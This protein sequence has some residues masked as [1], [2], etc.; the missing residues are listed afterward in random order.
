MTVITGTLNEDNFAKSPSTFDGIELIVNGSDMSVMG[1]SSNSSI[2]G[3][4]FHLNYDG[5]PE[6]LESL[7]LVVKK[8]VGYQKVNQKIEV[9]SLKDDPVI[10]AGKQLWIKNIAKTEQGIEITVANDEDVGV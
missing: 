6:K 7:E 10:L 3:R 1:S 8:F 9:S 4:E 5:L 2:T